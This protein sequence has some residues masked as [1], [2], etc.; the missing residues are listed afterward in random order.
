MSKRPKE[1]NHAI[2]LK[3][4]KECIDIEMILIW[5]ERKSNRDYDRVKKVNE[6]DSHFEQIIQR[7]IQ[8]Q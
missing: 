1:T 4:A 5:R 8:Y 2:G 3:D 7:K 6:L